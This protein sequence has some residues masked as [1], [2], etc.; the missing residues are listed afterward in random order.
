MTSDIPERYK[1]CCIHNDETISGFFGEYRWLSNMHRCEVVYGGITF[2]SVENAYQFAK[3]EAPTVDDIELFRSCSP[4]ESK[5][6]GRT[7]KLRSDWNDNLKR[8]VMARCVA[9]KFDN[10]DL[11]NMLLATDDKQLTEFNNWGDTFWGVDVDL[12]GCNELGNILMAT[13]RFHKNAMI[14]G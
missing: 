1:N 8:Y 5:K 14:F 11:R 10:N 9:S 12:G 6:L 7:V 2:S 13:R 4:F 3:I